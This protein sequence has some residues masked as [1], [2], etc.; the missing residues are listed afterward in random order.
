MNHACGG[1]NSY[2]MAAQLW[3]ACLAHCK[4]HPD[5]DPQWQQNCS[6]ELRAGHSGN[7]ER[8]AIGRECG[9][10]GRWVDGWCQWIMALVLTFRLEGLRSGPNSS[11]LRL[12][13]SSIE[14]TALTYAGVRSREAALGLEEA[15][16]DGQGSAADWPWVG[17]GTGGGSRAGSRELQRRRAISISAAAPHSRKKAA[18]A[19]TAAPAAVAVDCTPQS[20]QAG[21]EGEG[22]PG[23]GAAGVRGGGPWLGCGVG[24]ELSP[25][26]RGGL[27]SGLA[28]ARGGVGVAMGTSP[29]LGLGL[30][31]GGDSSSSR[32]PSGCTMVVRLLG[33]S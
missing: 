32:G 13:L 1:S 24:L 10:A 17:G 7:K 8:I 12:S 25:G 29:G 26:L 4:R 23:L 6:L 15:H 19:P 18:T 16:R 30:G 3:L 27:G 11:K 33:T 31:G 2:I 28:G 22:A 14:V 9:R 21:G 20:V 5:P